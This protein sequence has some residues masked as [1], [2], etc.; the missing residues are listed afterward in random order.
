MQTLR[1]LAIDIIL[2]ILGIY[3]IIEGC[4]HPTKWFWAVIGILDLLLSLPTFITYFITLN[5]KNKKNKNIKEYC[6]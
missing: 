2:L 4:S 3:L 1:N 6:Q 5:Y